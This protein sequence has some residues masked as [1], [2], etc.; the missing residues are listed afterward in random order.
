MRP[1][2]PPGRFQSLFTSPFWRNHGLQ[3]PATS[4]VPVSGAEAASGINAEG[5]FV[6]IDR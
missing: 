5:P 3:V 1:G 2:R 6:E 4:A